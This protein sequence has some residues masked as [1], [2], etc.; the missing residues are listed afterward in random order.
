M[1]FSLEISR[2]DNEAVLETSSA[3]TVRDGATIKL[4]TVLR[5]INPAEDALSRLL[6]RSGA[7]SR[8]ALAIG[9][10]RVGYGQ[11]FLPTSVVDTGRTGTAW[12]EPGCF[13]IKTCFRF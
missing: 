2:H 1:K 11:I 13:Q 7:A 6:A 9:G 12:E 4:A 10:L 8:G 5:R 3:E